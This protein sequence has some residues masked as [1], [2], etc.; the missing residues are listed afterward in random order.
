MKNLQST[1]GVKFFLFMLFM[2]GIGLNIF[3]ILDAEIFHWIIGRDA[4][5][6]SLSHQNASDSK[7]F[8]SW[9]QAKKSILLVIPA[10]CKG[11]ACGSGTGFV[12]KPGY[13]ATNAHVV[14]CGVACEKFVLR[15]YKGVNHEAKLEAIAS[16]QRSED[17]AILSVSGLSLPPLPLV[18]SAEYE[19][20]HDGEEVVTI[21]YPLPG[22]ASTADKSSVSGKGTIS[23][24]K[25]D[26]GIF[27]T[28]GM[29]L[30]SGNSGGPVFIVANRKVLGV[31]VGVLRGEVSPGNAPVEGVDYVIPINRL[32]TFFLEKTGTDLQ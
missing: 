29:N 32:K 7:P 14:K 31:A 25:T 21:G 19:T 28:S 10:D 18:N 26:E 12:I 4:V 20:E 16:G 13:V 9:E 2:I 1:A 22:I 11:N 23:T 30:N 17:L 15:D 6:P 8:A 24:F 27:I 5:S 3:T